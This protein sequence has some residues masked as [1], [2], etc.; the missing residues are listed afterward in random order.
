MGNWETP[1]GFTLLELLIT[2][3]VMVCLLV[4]AAPSFSSLAERMKMERLADSLQAYLYQAKAEAVF[5]N[6]DLWAHI[7]MS[8][9]PDT[10]GNWKVVLTDAA[11]PGTGNTLM[12]F[13]GNP[14]SNISFSVAGFSSNQIK[15]DGV[16]GKI[17]SGSVTFHPVANSASVLKLKASFG[18]SRI[19]VC[20]QRGARYG[21]PACS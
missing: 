20:G 5:R 1:R 16:R 6:Q 3:A 14:Y 10:T 12:V 13:S 21:Y 19:I 4:F 17:K 11:T 8:A 7:E 9:E 15:F 18:A 2:L